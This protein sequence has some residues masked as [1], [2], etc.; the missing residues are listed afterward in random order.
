MWEHLMHLMVGRP[1]QVNK[2]LHL[3][4][5]CL[6]CSGNLAAVTNQR[7]A[8]SSVNEMTGEAEARK[9][10]TT[11]SYNVKALQSHAA[12]ECHLAPAFCRMIDDLTE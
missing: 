1:L 3:Y 6:I 12:L 10:A 7:P 5:L 4:R 9:I 2:K 11:A 8:H